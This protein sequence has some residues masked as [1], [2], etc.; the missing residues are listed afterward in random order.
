MLRCARCAQDHR[1]DRSGLRERAGQRR[2]PTDV[3][4][5]QID[6]VEADDAHH[7]H[8]SGGVGVAH[9][10][11]EEHLLRGPS[12][13]RGFRVHHFLGTDAP[14]EKAEPPVDLAQPLLAVLIVRVLAAVPVARRPGHHR[15]HRRPFLEQEKPVL[16]LEPRQSD[17]CDLVLDERVRR[18]DAVGTLLRGHRRHLREPDAS[19]CP[20]HHGISKGVHDGS[21]GHEQAS[22]LWPRDVTALLGDWSRGNRTAPGAATRERQSDQ[23]AIRHSGRCSVPQHRRI[24]LP[25]P[26]RY[27]PVARSALCLEP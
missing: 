14:A 27:T 17:R 3:A 5:V 22:R 1:V 8:C 19:Y 16:V 18:P 26:R 11:T 24:A 25:W 21:T 12:G 15:C 20:L 23:P 4:A 9:G 10:R 6:F 13:P 7:P 2:H